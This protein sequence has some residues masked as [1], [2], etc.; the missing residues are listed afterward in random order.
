M[1]I[2]ESARQVTFTNSA[3]RRRIRVAIRGNR[4]ANPLGPE[5]RHLPP[6]QPGAYR[7][8]QHRDLFM[9]PKM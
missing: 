6:E 1:S 2:H 7:I 4:R 9:G 8:T 5:R 3:G